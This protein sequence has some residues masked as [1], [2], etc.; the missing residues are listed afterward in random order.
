MENVTLE[1][2]VALILERS[3]AIEQSEEV[4]LLALS[5]RVL[6]DDMI[7]P[8]DNPPFDRSPIDG[9]AC[10]AADVANAT[11]E[12][13]VRLTV[14]E[15]IDAG[16][17]SDEEV[18]AGQAVRIMTGAAIPPGCDCCIRQESTDYGESSVEIYAGVPA[19]TNYCFK[20]EDFKKGTLLIK[21]DTRLSYAEASIIASM[22]FAKAPVYRLPRV[23]LLTTGDEVTMPGEA[24]QAGKIYNSNQTMLAARMLELGIRPFMIDSI[25]D[26]PE[27]MAAAL[28][29][30]TQNADLIITTGGVSVG[31]KDIMH[32]A[33]PKM[34]AQRVFW[35]VLL[36]P[37]SPVI[38]ST[39]RG[40]PIIS[41]SGN[42]FGAAVNFELLIRPLLSKITHGGVL[43][44]CRQSAAM[45]DPFPKSS[46]G[47][48][49]IRAIYHNGSVHMPKGLHSSGALSSL[50][51]CN[52]LVDIKPGTDSLQAGDEVEIIL[53]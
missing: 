28:R 18:L 33:L 41:L 5:G 2:A 53:L 37:G 23:A 31:K 30:A 4:S 17:Y 48:R 50:Q 51:G 14:R 34:G 42:P 22:G 10:R 12:K 15:E 35:R 3:A 43:P 44:A 25:K 29:A 21:K 45:A 16:Q 32:E 1:Q 19:W 38:F 40:I 7:A 11:R 39:Y 46:R 52:C 13:P 36:K 20:G 8:L 24:L 6:T 27:K 49:F 47:R 26:E 9:Y